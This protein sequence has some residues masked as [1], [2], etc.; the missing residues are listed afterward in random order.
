VAFPLL[1]LIQG[2][3]AL[4]GK[5]DQE[6][7]ARQDAAARGEALAYP[8]AASGGKGADLL[9][10]AAPFLKQEKAERA[11]EEDDK[12]ANRFGGYNG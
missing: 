6:Q 10:A 5:K 7:Q 9:G 3:A 1:A 12:F 8:G 2:V 4:K 11:P